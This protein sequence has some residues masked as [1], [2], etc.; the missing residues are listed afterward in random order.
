MHMFVWFDLNLQI[1]S[2]HMYTADP[3]QQTWNICLKNWHLF[4]PHSSHL[5]LASVHPLTSSHW[6]ARWARH[7]MNGC[8]QGNQS[9][10]R[11][12]RTWRRVALSFAGRSKKRG[13]TKRSIFVAFPKRPCSLFRRSNEK[14]E[15]R[16]KKIRSTLKRIPSGRFEARSAL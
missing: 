10:W 5:L 15:K 6:A 16:R 14:R 1:L 8:S 4:Y 13:Q 12:T 2:V 7:P 11:E 9:S 3:T